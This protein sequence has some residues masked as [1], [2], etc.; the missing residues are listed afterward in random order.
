MVGRLL[1]LEKEGRGVAGESRSE[2]W[3][4]RSAGGF[5]DFRRTFLVAGENIVVLLDWCHY[6]FRNLSFEGLS[7]LSFSGPIVCVVEAQYS[8]VNKAHSIFITCKNQIIMA[9]D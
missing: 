3:A 7:A 4:W 1:G 5:S 6:H 9:M 8:P 2:A